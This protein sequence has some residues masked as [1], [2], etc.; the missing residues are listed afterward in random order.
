MNHNTHE[1]PKA[2]NQVDCSIKKILQVY[3]LLNSNTCRHWYFSILPKNMWKTSTKI[4]YIHKNVG[5][6]Q[7]YINHSFQIANLFVISLLWGKTTL[8]QVCA[9]VDA[10][11]CVQIH[12]SM[13]ACAMHQLNTQESRRFTVYTH[14]PMGV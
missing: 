13:G 1:S 8:T 7:T 2:V 5:Y 10:H 14:V 3:M 6:V 12:T 9:R 4:C 11:T